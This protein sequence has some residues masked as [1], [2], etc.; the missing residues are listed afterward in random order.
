MRA[1]NAIFD[2]P[3]QMSDAQ[4]ADPRR[5]GEL[6]W[7]WPP[8]SDDERPDEALFERTRPAGVP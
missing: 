3:G 1:S 2:L 5:T 8:A 6:T 4:R 7:T